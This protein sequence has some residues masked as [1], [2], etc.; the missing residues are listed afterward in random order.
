VQ[1]WSA[2]HGAA[3][4]FATSYVVEF[5]TS[6]STTTTLGGGWAFAIT[7][8]QRVGSSGPDSLGLFEIDPRTGDSL[9]GKKKTKTVA[10]ELDVSPNS[11]AS[12]FP[13]PGIPHVGLDIDAVRSVATSPLGNLT[14]LVNRRIAVF[15]DYDAAARRLDVRVQKLSGSPTSRSAPDR[16]RSKLYISYS[17]IRLSDLVNEFSYVGFSTR[18]PVEDLARYVLRS[19]NFS[20][21]WLPVA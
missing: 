10:I 7:P 2:K 21:E 13:D 15:V 14:T 4:S 1:L 19:W 9:R 8:D 12:T 6:G 17:P 3:A 18:V 16:T 5:Q 20:T 11:L